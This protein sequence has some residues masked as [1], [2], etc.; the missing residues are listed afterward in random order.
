MEDS[1]NKIEYINAAVEASKILRKLMLLCITISIAILIG[2]ITESEKRIKPHENL[3]VLKYLYNN[4]PINPS[5]IENIPEDED[6]IFNE[7]LDLVSYYSIKKKEDIKR[8]YSDIFEDDI[9]PPIKIPIINFES[10]LNNIKKYSG[11]VYIILLL[12]II[13]FLEKD[14]SNYKTIF[15][16]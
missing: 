2:I 1:R 11:I 12:A 14:F 3:N 16:L 10:S 7:A 13:Y 15:R 8:E 5:D 4:F 6:E 9:N